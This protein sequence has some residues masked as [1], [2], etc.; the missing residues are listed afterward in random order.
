VIFLACLGLATCSIIH[1][2]DK[3][4]LQKHL[5]ALNQVFLV[6]LGLAKFLATFC[7]ILAKF[8]SNHLVTLRVTERYRFALKHLITTPQ[9]HKEKIV[10]L[11]YF[12][13]SNLSVVLIFDSV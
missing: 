6:K 7:K 10:Q 12:K 4:R 2:S 9:H 3:Q 5:K 8:C 1:I 11:K 13:S